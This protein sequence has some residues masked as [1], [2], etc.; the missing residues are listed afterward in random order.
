MKNWRSIGSGV[1]LQLG[2]IL[3]IVTMTDSFIHQAKLQGAPIVH[4]E[5]VTPVI[6]PAYNAG[7]L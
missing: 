1:G 5:E 7:V 3:T 2:E 4:A 6:S